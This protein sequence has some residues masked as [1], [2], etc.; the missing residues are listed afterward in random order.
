MI[1]TTLFWL[2]LL[3]G[4]AISVAASM[5]MLSFVLSAQYS[6][7][8][9]IRA[10]GEIGWSTSNDSI[11]MAV[12]L[13]ILMGEILMRAGIAERMYE[14]MRQWM[15]WLPGGLMNANIGFCAVFSASSGSAVATAATIGTVAIPEIK[16]HGY[17]ERL[18]LGTLAAGGTLDI[19][20][21]P[22]INLIVYGA[23]TDTSIPQLYLAGFLPGF[24]CALLMIVTVIAAC[25][26]RPEWGGRRSPTDWPTRLRSLLDLI[27]PLLIFLV[28]IGSIYAGLAT[29][30]EAAALGLVFSCVL[31]AAR[32]QLTIGV[33]KLAMESCMKITGMTMAIL[34]AAN[35]LLFVMAMIGLNQQLTAGITT[36]GL[37]PYQT[38]TIVIIVLVLLGT[39][40]ETLPMMIATVPIIAPVMFAFG[41]DP[42]WFGILIILLMQ[43]GMISPPVGVTLFVVQSIRRSGSV[44]DVFIGSLPFML[45]LA[46]MIGLLVAFPSIALIVPEMLG[47]YKPA[48]LR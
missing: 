18:F 36:L 28:V 17:N 41:F 35:F 22:S 29:A 16:R 46:V 9:L 20:I 5:A 26:W 10:L 45:T 44:N 42:V 4:A 12:P 37:G 1:A 25:L 7:M 21:P 27:P 2:C 34:V 39:F 8:P 40:M 32:R 23:L 6:S 48:V 31:A 15:S 3:M 14:A 24:I 38:L 11:I 19:L 33:I 13:Y 47:N 43:T 30:T